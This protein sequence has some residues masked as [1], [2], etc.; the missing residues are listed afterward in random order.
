[1]KKYPDI[2]A[3]IHAFPKDVQVLLRKMRTTI[4]KVAP[5][6]TEA[7]IYGVPTF[8]LGHNLVHFGGFNNH[9]SF[10]PTSSGVR[11]FKKELARY[12][13]SKGTIKFPLDTPLPLAL[14]TKITRFRVKENLALS[15]KSQK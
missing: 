8:K 6:A 1:M 7:I 2:D 15:K 12:E 14:I 4:K 11:V 13:T 10:F 9:V 3:Y 5:K